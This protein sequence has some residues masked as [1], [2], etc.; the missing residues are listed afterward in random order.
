VLAKATEEEAEKMVLH[1]NKMIMR[2]KK[3]KVQVEHN[4][5]K[6]INMVYD[7][8]QIVFPDV[9]FK[10]D[11]TL[12]DTLPHGWE[13]PVDCLPLDEVDSATLF[14]MQDDMNH[15]LDCQCTECIDF[16]SVLLSMNY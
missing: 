6:V 14:D 7:K 11:I 4:S 16:N 5:G 13:E 3:Y 2:R 15:P 1:K 10:E 9:E 12:V 8:R